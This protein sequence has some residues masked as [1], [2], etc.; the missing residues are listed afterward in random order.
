MVVVLLAVDRQILRPRLAGRQGIA[1][2][3]GPSWTW[4]ETCHGGKQVAMNRE[5][6]LPY[7]VGDV[8]PKSNCKHRKPGA[9]RERNGHSETHGVF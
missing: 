9:E 3:A 8:R 2:L 6:V 1:S 5:D 4:I 7:S